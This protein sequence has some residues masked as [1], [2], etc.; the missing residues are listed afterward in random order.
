MT[1]PKKHL[2]DMTDTEVA[3]LQRA[4]VAPAFDLMMPDDAGR[5]EMLLWDLFG[6]FFIAEKT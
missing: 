6:L 1:A 2:Q 5:Y 4:L 3:N